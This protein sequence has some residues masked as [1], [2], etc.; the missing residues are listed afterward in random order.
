MTSSIH[1]IDIYNL[2][3]DRDKLLSE[4]IKKMDIKGILT[5]SIRETLYSMYSMYSDNMKY[6]LEI[7]RHKSLDE[8]NNRK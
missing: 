6:K 2:D 8:I 7:K 1:H 3:D 4:L 5:H